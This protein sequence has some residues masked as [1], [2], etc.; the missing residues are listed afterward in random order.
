M[1]FSNKGII[2]RLTLEREKEAMRIKI[3]QTLQEQQK[4][5]QQ[6]KALDSDPKA[7]EKVAREKYGMIRDG[8]TVYKVRKETE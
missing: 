2:Q 4:L 1:M 8:E 6:S 3:N 7:I 5:Q